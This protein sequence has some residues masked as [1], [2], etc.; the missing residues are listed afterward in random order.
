MRESPAGRCCAGK[1]GLQATGVA[2]SPCPTVLPRYCR[3]SSRSAS[4]ASRVSAC[5]LLL[6]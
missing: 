3:F 1:K 5:K 6:E 4:P 2:T